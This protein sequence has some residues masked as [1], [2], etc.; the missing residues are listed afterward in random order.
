MDKQDVNSDIAVIRTKVESIESHLE[1]M[2]GKLVDTRKEVAYL[3]LILCIVVVILLLAI[4]QVRSILPV[5]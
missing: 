5:L 2:N 3:K 4:P 1:K